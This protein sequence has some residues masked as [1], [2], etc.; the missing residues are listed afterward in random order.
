MRR[1]IAKNTIL[2]TQT[3][4][5]KNPQNLGC[6][7]S[8]KHFFFQ[9][10]SRFEG[11]RSQNFLARRCKS[12]VYL[13]SRH[14]RARNTSPDYLISREIS[15]NAKSP[16]HP[17]F[18]KNFRKFGPTQMLSCVP[19]TVCDVW[20]VTTT[21]P[22]SHMTMIT[23]DFVRRPS[24]Y[25]AVLLYGGLYCNTAQNLL[26]CPIQRQSPVPRLLYCNTAIQR[27][28][29][30]QYSAIQQCSNTAQYSIQRNTIPLRA[31][32]RMSKG[33]IAEK[34][35]SLWPRLGIRR[36]GRQTQHR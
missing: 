5:E 21:H 36:P 4:P 13:P 35:P 19:L 34:C 31:V 29:T 30:A 16:T 22:C 14:L 27:A 28:I 11:S 7:F 9:G 26:Y 10:F 2:P 8:G 12:A 3:D 33:L 32:D 20:V 25:T 15:G 24:A 1:K 23:I 18:R 17:F 6:D